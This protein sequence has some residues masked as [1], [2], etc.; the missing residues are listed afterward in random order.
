MVYIRSGRLVFPISF[1]SYFFSPENIFKIFM[2]Y[3][4]EEAHKG[5][6]CYF[7]P[8]SYKGYIAGLNSLDSLKSKGNITSE[9][10]IQSIYDKLKIDPWMDYVF[11]NLNKLI[12]LTFPQDQ[13]S[14]R[15][16]YINEAQEQWVIDIYK[17][18]LKRLFKERRNN[19]ETLDIFFELADVFSSR[20]I[21]LKNIVTKC[22]V[23]ILRIKE[24]VLENSRT[25]TDRYNVNSLAD[26]YTDGEINRYFNDSFKQS[27]FSD[28]IDNVKIVF[29]WSTNVETDD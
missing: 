4:N 7:S 9:M 11:I 27:L 20:T 6:P 10:Y 29:P 2:W 25:I 18:S 3:L 19:W 13:D 22:K 5:G 28:L 15:K 16:I 1:S 23:R 8:A 12:E 24:S 14:K 26:D 17:E 21:Q